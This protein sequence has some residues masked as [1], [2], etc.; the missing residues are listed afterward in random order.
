MSGEFV[1]LHLH[2]E[3]SLLDGACR[4]PRLLERAAELGQTAVALTDHGNMF[5]AVEFFK[6]AKKAGI[7]PVIGCEAYVAP[8]RM[9]DRTR[10]G[11]GPH[12]L[13][14]LCKNT[15]GYKNL[16][17]MISM[18]WL[19]GFYNRPRIDKELLAGHSEGLIALSGCLFGEVAS[20][21]RAADY[22]GALET[23]KWYRQVFG[24]DYYLEIQDQ[25]LPEQKA[26]NAQIRQISRTLG[27]PMAATNDVHYVMRDDARA[28]KILMCI[29]T[30][31]TADS[32]NAMEFPTDEYY[33][34]SA[35]EM[36]RLFAD[37]PG[38]VENT[39]LIADKCDFE[40]EFGH[41][42]LPKF[43]IPEGYA[44]HGLY[45]RGCAQKGLER[46]YP[47][48]KREEAGRRLEYELSV[49]EKMG[50]TDYFLIVADFI[51][52]AKS[53]G[54]PVGPG[55]GSGASSLVGYCLGITGVDPLRYKLVF[56]RFLNPERVSMPDFDIDFCYERRQE[57]ID[58]VVGKYG[59]D[60]VAQIV[61]FG[62]MKARAAIR[63]AGRAL[64]MSY[65]SVDAVARLIPRSLSVTLREVL[66]APGSE[67]RQR[68]ENDSGTREL[69]QT[70]IKLEGMARHAST[71]AAGV[72]ITDEPVYS[73]VPLA[74]NGSCVVTQYT[75][76]HLEELGLLKM[77]FLGLRYLTVI[78]DAEDYIR[79]SEPGFDIEKIPENDPNAYRLLA[80]GDTDGVFQLESAGMRQLICELKPVCI[81]DIMTAI[82]LYRPGPMK[83]I[84]Q[85]LEGRAHPENIRYADARLADALRDTF[86]VFAYQEQVTQV[87][88]DLAGFTYGQ[89]DLVRRAMAKKKPGE[90][91]KQ[92][93][94]FIDGEEDEN[95]YTIVPGAVARGVSRKTA[96]NI[97]DAMEAFAGYGFNKC[98]AAPYA[99]IA[100]RTAYLR[101]NYYREYMSAL[102]TSMS[103]DSKCTQY[104]EDCKKHGVKVEPPDV[105][106]SFAGF[107]PSGGGII[108]GL[109]GIKNVGRGLIGALVEERRRAGNFTSFFDFCS[110]LYSREL[111]SRALESLIKAGAFDRL[112]DN[113]RSM[114]C[115]VPGI[116]ADLAGRGRGSVEGQLGLFDGAEEQLPGFRM[117]R[118]AEFS[119][120]EILSQEHEVTGMFLS[121]HPLDRY[122]AYIAQHRLT[123]IGPA[124]HDENASQL[125]GAQVSVLGFVASSSVKIT[126]NG[127]SMAFL[128]FEDRTGTIE[129]VIFPKIFARWSEQIAEGKVL[130][131]HGH[132]SVREKE[133]EDETEGYEVKLIAESLALPPSPSPAPA[134]GA[135]GPK[136]A[137]P[138]VYLRVPSR[139]S[140][141][142]RQISFIVKY[143]PGDTPIYVFFE[144]T[145]KLNL[146][147]AGY[148]ITPTPT[149]LAEF[150]KLLGG[151]NVKYIEQ[152]DRT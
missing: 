80:R 147:P 96:E 85:Y 134:P 110:R 34:K 114:M 91:E 151:E 75:M 62:T 53:R 10:A 36:K 148:N 137:G 65:A 149:V 24:P 83:S 23:A 19:N 39:V 87:C 57:V 78:R 18:A 117:P 138:G 43:T 128:R 69:V 140:E 122:A 21:I 130:L 100:Y 126:K 48:E 59:A 37:Y 107:V 71:H 47:P 92:R 99:L 93:R 82:S 41:T 118:E 2:S 20:R 68:C 81:E 89:A 12:H 46:L 64:G 101:A 52:F 94:R 150:G 17:Y 14:L 13:I 67:L 120:E 9:S 66:D 11:G 54:I 88:R 111:N 116:L 125:D 104:I 98:H 26:V 124:V 8:G 108:Y 77:D 112:P 73:Y 35:E 143:S 45:L 55:R 95:G 86:G 25:G 63:D 76:N 133:S 27:I 29:R 145:G 139:D 28:Q 38:A 40:F 58:Y 16:I 146:A 79:L 72:V 144:D 129:A 4:F 61:T 97:F 6:A 33:L 119:A 127:G 142:M 90:M 121:A 31:T 60:H 105:N 132:L 7:K 56:E 50:F 123:T 113:R 115:A 152:R 5:G 32:E 102:I 84:P 131:I 109:T 3:Y 141:Q 74:V 136:A 15:A 51:G 42:K 103:G 49:I 44:S 1:H 22:A 70:A 30:G 106:R 135:R